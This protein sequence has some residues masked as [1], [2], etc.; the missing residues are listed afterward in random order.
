MR[1]HVGHFLQAHRDERRTLWEWNFPSS[2]V[3]SFLITSSMPWQITFIKKNKRPFSSWKEKEAVPGL[4][5]ILTG[6]HR[7]CQRPSNLRQDRFFR[8]SLLLLM[9]FV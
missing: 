2:A 6:L 9:L 3:Q 1:V 5:S 8:F 4:R 7:V